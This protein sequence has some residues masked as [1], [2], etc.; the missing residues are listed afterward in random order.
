[1][2][3]HPTW[4]E[5]ARA[6]ITDALADAPRGPWNRGL[7]LTARE[8]YRPLALPRGFRV[9][10]VDAA[11]TPRRV[12]RCHG[13]GRPIL[14]VPGLYATLDEG[15]F[16]RI[17]RVAAAETGRPVALLED[18]LARPTVALAGPPRL[19]STEPGRELGAVA[20]M[21]GGSVD[22]LALSAGL[23]AAWSAP[24]SALARAVGFS[25]IRDPAA[26]AAHLAHTWL[27]RTYYGVQHRRAL[28]GTTLSQRALE[29]ALASWPPLEPPDGQWLLVHAEDDPVVP[30][31]TVDGLPRG[32]VCRV[33]RGGHLGFGVLAGVG[34]YVAPLAE[35]SD[36]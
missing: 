15:L 21:L 14:V 27:I 34:I 19:D 16:L 32:R 4:L 22:V 24:A 28:G 29:E 7:W 5:R 12:L 35:V 33:P 26:L 11:G 1:M 6:R 25:G 20:T 23:V 18:R 9:E 13:E 30:V 2:S 31:Q 36:D 10:V 3:D 17:A 8:R